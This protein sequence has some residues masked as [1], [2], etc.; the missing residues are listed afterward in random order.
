MAKPPLSECCR[1]AAGRQGK[2]EHLRANPR[3]K[4]KNIFYCRNGLARN[5]GKNKKGYGGAAFVRM[6]QGCRRQA[7]EKRS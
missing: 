5:E 7:G 2:S 3:F 4:K 1:D 6:L